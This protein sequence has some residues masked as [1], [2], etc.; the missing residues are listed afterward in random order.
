MVVLLVIAYIKNGIFLLFRGNGVGR[1]PRGRG[2]LIPAVPRAVE[3]LRGRGFVRLPIQTVLYFL[4]DALGAVGRLH[5]RLSRGPFGPRHGAQNHALPRRHHPG[6]C[7]GRAPASV[8]LA[9][10]H[11]GGRAGHV[12]V[13]QPAAE[14][15]QGGRGRDTPDLLP[16]VHPA[17]H[18]LADI[19]LPL[20]GQ[21]DIHEAHRLALAGLGAGHRQADVGAADLPDATRHGGRR[22]GRYRAVPLDEGRVDPQ[23]VDLDRVGVGRYPHLKDG[24]GAGLLGQPLGQKAGGAGL[25]GGG[26][27]ALFPQPLHDHL[28]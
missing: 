5:H 25:G 14:Q 21:G 24:G 4:D 15:I 13:L 6:G 19:N 22:L 8:Y 3:F 1:F 2:F 23:G 26:L 11:V 18:Q 12:G 7:Q 9:G 10:L 28:L 27:E 16:L 20:V 17:G